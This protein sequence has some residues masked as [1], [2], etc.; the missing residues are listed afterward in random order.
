MSYL[1]KNIPSF[2]TPFNVPQ[3]TMPELPAGNSE[4]V[5]IE[6]SFDKLELSLPNVN[7]SSNAYDLAKGLI[8]EL[9]S[10]STYSKQYDWNKS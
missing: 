1:E 5:H 6:N 2:S 8:N 7:D 3:I 9:H 10:L 4:R